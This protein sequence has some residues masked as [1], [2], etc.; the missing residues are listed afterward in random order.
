M[1]EERPTSADTE[2]PSLPGPLEHALEGQKK[3]TPEIYQYYIKRLFFIS[4]FED[5]KKTRK[6]SWIFAILFIIAGTAKYIDLINYKKMALIITS[7]I[8]VDFWTHRYDLI[9]LHKEINLMRES[10]KIGE[11]DSLIK[12]IIIEIAIYI[13]IYSVGACVAVYYTIKSN[14]LGEI[15]NFILAISRTK[16]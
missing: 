12:Q 8:F 6:N 13:S 7:V 16:I 14:A 2:G 11:R 15:Q 1:N 5:A 10:I 4:D 3:W 9:Y